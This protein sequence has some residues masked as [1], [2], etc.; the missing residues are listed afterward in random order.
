MGQKNNKN[1]KE[2]P[3]RSYIP[4]LYTNAD[5]LTN[6]MDELKLVINSRQETPLIIIVTEVKA[7][8][9][10]L[11]HKLVEYQIDMFEM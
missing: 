7:K 3:I 9:R 11:D 4:C 2:S 1:R 5:A 10:H 6:K 8:H